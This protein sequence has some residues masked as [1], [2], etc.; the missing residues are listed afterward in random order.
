MNLFNYNVAELQADPKATAEEA[1]RAQV[2]Q[3]S[4]NRIEHYISDLTLLAGK[5][6]R[7]IDTLSALIVTGTKIME[8]GLHT[9]GR[10]KA[11]EG[12]SDAFLEATAANVKTAF[13][14]AVA[15]MDEC[16][17]DLGAWTEAMECA[18]PAMED[19]T[20]ISKS[21][22]RPGVKTA[23][24]PAVPEKQKPE[25]GPR[26]IEEN[27]QPAPAAEVQEPTPMPVA[28][29]L[30]ALGYTPREEGFEEAQV[31]EESEDEF[32]TY[33]ETERTELFEG[34]LNKLEEQGVA[35]GLK[36]K[37]WAKAQTE[38]QQA[39][40]AFPKVAFQRLTF[41]VHYRPGKTTWDI[42]SDDEIKA[43]ED[44]Q[45]LTEAD[46]AANITPLDRAA[47]EE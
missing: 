39:I 38:W 4:T 10:L 27:G 29:P 25:P 45:A 18:K 9:Q 3:N 36:R 21:L 14:H 31:V 13:R 32:D 47:G 43:Y 15:L 17:L 11:A 35:D 7:C 24:T 34:L 8:L 26:L 23:V 5:D 16:D 37:N 42:P 44:S 1:R 20:R 40:D 33:D 41:A 22:E 6:L 12:R 46:E 19:L 28:A 2:A 30:P